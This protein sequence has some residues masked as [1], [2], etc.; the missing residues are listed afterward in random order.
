T[1]LVCL[2]FSAVPVVGV[3][4]GVVYYR[5]TLVSGLRGYVP[6]VRGCLARVV[7]RVL[8]FAVLALQPIPL[9][10][11]LVLPLLCIT[12]Y[13]VYRRALTGHALPELERAEALPSPAG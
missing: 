12:A 13:L 7:T 2:A 5:M 9:V 4:P 1:L 10:G 6:P 8:G 3:I 11:A